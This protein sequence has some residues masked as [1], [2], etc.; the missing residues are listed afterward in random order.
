MGRQ[1]TA[2]WDVVVGERIRARRERRGWLQERLAQEMAAG[3]M[4]W[5]RGTVAAV[6]GGH[7]KVSALELVTVAGVFGRPLG[8]FFLDDGGGGIP[9]RGEVWNP[10]DVIVE[11]GDA[12][13]VRRPLG[14]I[15]E[16]IRDGLGAT[17]GITGGPRLSGAAGVEADVKAARALGIEVAELQALAAQTWGRSLE[18]EREARVDVEGVSAR[19]VQA[20][21]GHVTRRLVEELRAARGQG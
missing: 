13:P 7:R 12:V 18:R 10:Y 21:R 4:A 17:E 16:S 5:Q 8:D 11:F 19:T 9:I 2:A 14:T 3:G 6:E 1:V 15:V 20:R